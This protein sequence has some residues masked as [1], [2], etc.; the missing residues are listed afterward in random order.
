MITYSRLAAR[1]VNSLYYWMGLNYLNNY[2]KYTVQTPESGLNKTSNIVTQYKIFQLTVLFFSRD[3]TW[4]ILKI[5]P[6]RE[7]TVSC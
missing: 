7:S 4:R 2:T 3:T 1:L 6:L 5:T